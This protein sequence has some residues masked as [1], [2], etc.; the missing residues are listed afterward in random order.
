[1]ASR[2]L[3]VLLVDDEP[4]LLEGLSLHLRRRFDVTT[5]TSGAQGLAAMRKHGPFAVVVSD[6]CMPAMVGTGFLVRARQLSPDTIRIVLTGDADAAIEAINEAE[7]FRFLRKPCP[8][9]TLRAA[10]QA[11]ADA[12]RSRVEE[13]E[14]LAASLSGSVQILANLLA[15]ASPTAFGRAHRLR[16]HA[17]ELAARLGVDDLTSIEMSAL[18]SQIGCISL[19]NEVA[20]RMYYGRELAPDERDLVQRLPE[21]T[22]SLLADIPHLDPVR[23]IVRWQQAPYESPVGSSGSEPRGEDLPLGARI[24]KLALDYDVLETHR[25]AEA[26]RIP[27]LQARAIE[28]DPRV[29]EAFTEMLSEKNMCGRPAQVGLRELQVGMVLADDLQTQRGRLLL[30]RGLELTPGVLAHMQQF[31]ASEIREP[32]RVLLPPEPT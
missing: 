8:P 24:L 1:V 18:L 2:K 15:L 21:L 19:P 3:K 30:A 17:V 20:E 26:E 4:A 6:M 32:I 25:I 14:Q 23:E 9:D 10:V 16:R 11:A 31:E 22:A 27:K 13:R 28:Y 29:L 12:H 7:V 5:A